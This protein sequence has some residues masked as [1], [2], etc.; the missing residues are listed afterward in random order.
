VLAKI[1]NEKMKV[2]A[3]FF[4]DESPTPH[5]AEVEG[6]RDQGE[7]LAAKLLKQIRAE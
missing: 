6:G 4:P 3:Q 1:E 7:R 2:R 5:E